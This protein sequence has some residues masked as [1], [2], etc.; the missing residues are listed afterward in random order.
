MRKEKQTPVDWF[1]EKIKTHFEH[2][3]DLLETLSFTYATARQKEREQQQV[4]TGNELYKE[5]ERWFEERYKITDIED[6]CKYDDLT[7]Y[8]QI[9]E[10][11]RA[12]LNHIG[13]NCE[14][15]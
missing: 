13:L 15:E 11:V 9:F 12:F 14:E 7:S 6:Y 3:G 1:F 10:D 8:G 4:I 2:D 5:L